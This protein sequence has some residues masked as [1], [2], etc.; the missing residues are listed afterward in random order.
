D[1][2]ASLF[3]RSAH[4]SLTEPERRGAE[5]AKCV[6]I[7]ARSTDE[8][9]TLR[10]ADPY[11]SEPQHWR[12]YYPTSR[13]RIGDLAN[14]AAYDAGVEPDVIALDDHLLENMRAANR[15]ENI[16]LVLVDPWSVQLSDYSA[17]ARQYDDVDLPASIML[18]CWN[19]EDRD[20]SDS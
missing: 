16:L 10:N 15:T 8:I 11:G 19:I 6:F 20:T 2:I 9:G 4:M 13:E 3:Y 18:I 7:A 17:R 14:R 12:P 1:K 5:Y